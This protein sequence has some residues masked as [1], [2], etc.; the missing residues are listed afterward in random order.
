MTPLTF[1]DSYVVAFHLKRCRLRSRSRCCRWLAFL[2][3]GSR[4]DS[5]SDTIVFAISVNSVLRV[6]KY[7]SLE[8]HDWNDWRDRLLRIVSGV[9]PVADEEKKAGF[10]VAIEIR[11]SGEKQ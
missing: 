11:A 6:E 1:R 7:S 2:G 3:L 4:A 5:P 9:A 8:L 10:A